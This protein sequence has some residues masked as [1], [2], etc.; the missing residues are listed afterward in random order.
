MAASRGEQ[1]DCK[2]KKILKYSLSSNNGKYACVENS[3]E[4]TIFGDKD[5]LVESPVNA[6]YVRNYT[7]A[8]YNAGHDTPINHF[9]PD[10]LVASNDFRYSYLSFSADSLW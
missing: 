8:W 5:W 1:P 4:L 6:E 10:Q 9:E 3:V 2:E 7:T